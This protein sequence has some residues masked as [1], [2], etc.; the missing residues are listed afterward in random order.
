MSPV[1]ILVWIHVLHF[2]SQRLSIDSLVFFFFFF[3]GGGLAFPRKRLPPGH[4]SS[5]VRKRPVA[6]LR[7]NHVRLSNPSGLISDI[8]VL[9]SER[10][11]GRA[12]R[13]EACVDPAG[14]GGYRF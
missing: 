12:L 5:S 13:V 7:H 4:V 10:V 14:R 9:V 11:G 1:S 8:L 2:L 6:E 3:G